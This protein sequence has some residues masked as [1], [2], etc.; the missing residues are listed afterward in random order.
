M[1]S[2]EWKLRARKKALRHGQF[3]LHSTLLTPSSSLL[4]GGSFR[5]RHNGFC[6]LLC[7]SPGFR[8]GVAR[9]AN[10]HQ[11][12]A[13]AKVLIEPGGPELQGPGNAGA[14]QLQLGVQL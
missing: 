14:L 5:Q 3:A 12:G 13:G 7:G 10:L 11:Q 2:S 4:T 1:R 6:Q 8:V 9:R